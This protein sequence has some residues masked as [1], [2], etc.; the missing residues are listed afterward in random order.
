MIEHR[1]GDIFKDDEVHVI[2]HQ[3]N[4]YCTLASRTSS[5][6][7]GVIEKLYPEACDADGKTE[8]GDKGKLGGYSS[9]KGADGR[10]IVNCYSQTGMGSSDRNTDYNLILVIFKKIEQLIRTWND[11]NPT[12]KKN[13]AVPYG[14]GSNIAGGSWTIVEAVFKYVFENSTVKLIIMRLPTQTDLR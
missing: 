14:Y 13:L 4:L 3:A 9:A 10:T 11:A 5:G 7:A 6:I 2:A 8:K 1:V 12:N